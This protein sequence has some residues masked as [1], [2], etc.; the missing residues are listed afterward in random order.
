M[1]DGILAGPFGFAV[2]I[3]KNWD[4]YTGISRFGATQGSVEGGVKNNRRF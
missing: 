4:G 1:R 2:L 3:K